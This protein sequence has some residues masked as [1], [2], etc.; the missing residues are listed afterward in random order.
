MLGV[1]VR[2]NLLP[3]T[4]AASSGPGQLTTK[5]CEVSARKPMDALA[6]TITLFWVFVHS[7][8]GDS[9]FLFSEE[10]TARGFDSLT[11]DPVIVVCQQGTD[12]PAD[13]VGQPNASKSGLRSEELVDFFVVT[14]STAGEIGFN[15]LVWP[16][17]CADSD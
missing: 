15:R 16:A 5:A 13:I 4:H 8:R 11:V 9:D 1:I 7:L 6:M 12:C 10:C 17:Y 2:A 3:V 14:H